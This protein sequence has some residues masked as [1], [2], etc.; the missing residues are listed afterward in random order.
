MGVSVVAI[1]QA[2][3]ARKHDPDGNWCYKHHTFVENPAMPS[4]LDGR[5]TVCYCSKTGDLD[6][7]GFEAGSYSGYNE[8]RDELSELALGISADKLWTNPDPH[9]GKPF[10]EL[11]LIP[12]YA[13]AIGPVTSAKLLKDFN[14]YLAAA[15]K[16]WR[17]KSTAWLLE[18]YM[19]F[20]RAFQIAKGNGFVVLR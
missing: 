6:C 14:C 1:S 19:D 20:R 18:N 8:F 3:C 12:P 13:N 15:R 5:P 4:V 16:R 11:L 17:S 7:Y 10:V 9:M 2:R